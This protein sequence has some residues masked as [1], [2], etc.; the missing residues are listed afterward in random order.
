MAWNTLLGYTK[1]RERERESKKFCRKN[2]K[3]NTTPRKNTMHKGIIYLDIR[4]A[5]VLWGFKAS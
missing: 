3:L 2:C 4:L 1:K 5:E